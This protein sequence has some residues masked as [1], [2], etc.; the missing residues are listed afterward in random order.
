MS[1]VTPARNTKQR[2]QENDRDLALNSPPK[3]AVSRR[4][5]HSDS[6]GLKMQGS[7]G[8]NEFYKTMNILWVLL[9]IAVALVPIA[10]QG[11]Q[12]LDCDSVGGDDSH[13]CSCIWSTRVSCKDAD[14]TDVPTGIPPNIVILE[15]TGNKITQWMDL[16]DALF[17]E[18]R[19]VVVGN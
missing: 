17:S 8:N 1:S 7:G 10:V 2:A 6:R 13:V 16:W 4:E 15:L 12:P 5:G 14:L 9:T 19:E 18:H 11:Q 3:H